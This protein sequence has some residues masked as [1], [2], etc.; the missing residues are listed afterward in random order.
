MRRAVARVPWWEVAG[1][2]GG[3]LL[4]AV[5]ISWPLAANMGT[6]IA[7]GGA[8][9]DQSGYLWDFWNIAEHGLSL[10]GTDLQESISAPFGRESPGSVNVTLFT[11]LG[12]A[13]LVTTLWSPI[14]AYN[15]TVF[16]ALTL[17]AA[18]MYLLARWVGAGRWIAAWAGMAF[19]LFPYEQIRAQVHIPLAH[20][21]CLPIVVLVCLRWIERPSWRRSVWLALGLAAC[22]L[23][24]PYY[25][26]MGFVIVG[27][28]VIVGA[29]RIARTAGWRPLARNLG[30]VAL[31]V[32]AI[33]LVPLGLLFTAASGAIDQ[34]LR[35][36][37]EELVAYGARLSDYLLPAADNPF[38]GG[39]FGADTWAS[40][41]SPGGERTAFVGYVTLALAA[42]GTGL[43][44][45]RRSQA[46]SRQCIAVITAL[47]LLL[48]LMLFSSVSPVTVLGRSIDMPSSYLFDALPYLRVY[49]RFA[50]AV[51]AVLLMVAAIGL[52]RL[53]RG[54]TQT[55]RVAVISSVFIL[56]ALELPV[57]SPV[58]IP[59]QSDVPMWVGGVPPSEVPTWLWLKERQTDEIVYEYP[60][61]PD[62]GT[63]RFYMY[64]QT[65]HGHRITNGSLSPGQ[66]GESFMKAN[67]DVTWPGVPE[68]LAGLGIDLVTVN[69][70]AYERQ[71][72]TAPPADEPPPG[73]EVVKTFPNGSAVWR[74][75]ADPADAVAVPRDAGWWDPE[76][77]DGELWRWM[78]RRARVTVVAPEAGAYRITFP[79]RGLHAEGGARFDVWLSGPFGETERHTVGAERELSFDVRLPAGRSD[80]WL[81]TSGPRAQPVNP[82]DGRLGTIQVADWE[83]SRIGARVEAPTP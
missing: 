4:M 74:V 49:A 33:V 79:A 18:A 41:G 36:T 50:V 6:D 45:G 27:V 55:V 52:S 47:P 56:S 29:V 48:A 66:I 28:C 8:G 17:S 46:S 67:G 61:G 43:V 76:L 68:R 24:N 71:G 78:I 1:V 60:G 25:G 35:R 12:P 31:S 10:W 19:M 70:W 63:E 11:T 39:I 2:L 7:G 22:W 34:S 40:I 80:V 81:E 58:S 75:T 57:G 73:F 83:I 9:G 42:L 38:F 62:E 21:W 26:T 53:L 69:P 64:G 20:I 15:V 82:G 77:I 37:P 65:I 30:E 5:I 44:L 32:V 54:R 14:V 59:I 23:T 3:Y 13:W 51:M 72:G 16:L